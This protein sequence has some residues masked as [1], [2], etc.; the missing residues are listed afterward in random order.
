[1]TTNVR[2]CAPGFA[3]GSLCGVSR[4]HAQCFSRFQQ[5]DQRGRWGN[6][7]ATE[8]PP[9]VEDATAARVHPLLLR[10]EHTAQY[11]QY[12][13]PEMIPAIQPMK[14][15]PANTF[16]SGSAQCCEVTAT[17]N[18]NIGPTIKTVNKSQFRTSIATM[19]KPR[20]QVCPTHMTTNVGFSRTKASARTEPLSALSRYDSTSPRASIQRIDTAPHNAATSVSAAIYQ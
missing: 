15:T 18:A 2:R 10:A 9:I 4:G 17:S 20:K 5:G 3:L 14:Q 7:A 12:T 13:A 11:R 6:A 16:Q 19:P 1:M 8:T